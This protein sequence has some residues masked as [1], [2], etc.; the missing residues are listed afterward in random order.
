MM[1][2][3]PSVTAANILSRGLVGLFVFAAGSLPLLAQHD[4]AAAE[5]AKIDKPVVFLD[6]SPRL[7]AYQLNRLSNV[8]LLMVDRQPTDAKYAPVYESILERAKM[9]AKDRDEAVEALAKI[10]KSDRVTE[11]LSALERV[12]AK[13]GADKGVLN[14]LATLLAK[15]PAP[16]LAAK[17]AALDGLLGKAKL[18]ATKEAA[19]AGLITAS[20]NADA[21]WAAVAQDNAALAAIV[22]GLPRVQDEKLVASFQSKVAALVKTPPTPNLLRAAIAALPVMKGAEAENF[23]VLADLIQHGTERNAAIHAM[24]KLPKATWVKDL[25]GKVAQSLVE[26]A[27]KVPAAKRTEQDYLDA[28]QLATDLSLLLPTDAGKAIRKTLGGLS[29]RVVVL[30]T[31]HEQMFF[32]KTLIV[33]EAGKPVEIHFENPDAMPHNLVIV[34]PGAADEIGAIAEKMPPANDAKGRQFVPDS[35]KVLHATKLINPGEKTKLAFTAPAK[36]DKYPYICSFPGHS[37][38]MRGVLLVVDDLEDYLT[39]NPNEPTAPVITEW[40]LDTLAP[41][42]SKLGSGRNVEKGKELFTSVGCVSC[43]KLGENGLLYG[44][45]L[46][47]LFAKYKN[48]SKAILEQ[49]LEPSKTIEPRYR[50]Y[51]I[52]IG[53]DEP[54]TGFIVK[55]EGDTLFLQTGPGE[56]SIQKYAKKDIKAREPQQMSLMPAGL[57]NLLSEEQILDLLAYLQTSGK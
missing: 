11:L 13:E 17:K 26:F 1:R 10:R 29:V 55:E 56:T 28:T 43:H 51:A 44:P 18:A 36:A 30:K 14:D 50:S 15:S 39:K 31:L 48:D 37:Q 7:V 22:A 32:D 53:T 49:I 3:F 27:G 23:A 21:I 54:V 6:K 57:L 5:G 35:P 33:V 34:A 20:G 52:T 38:R 46:T 42:L 4:H 12:D 16:A 41:A 47:G 19:A 25:A 24:A 40:K 8:Q 9:T 45:E 2:L